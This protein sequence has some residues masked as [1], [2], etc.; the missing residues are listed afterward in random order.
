MKN[1]PSS[2][3]R[4]K[5]TITYYDDNAGSFF[6]A[7]IQIDASSLYSLFLRYLTPGAHILDAGCGSGRDSLYFIQHGYKVTALDASE[8][9][10]Q[11]ASQLIGQP[12]LN[13]KFDEMNFT[14]VFDGIWACASLLHIPSDGLDA[15]IGQLAQALRPGGILYMSFKYGRHEEMRNGRFFNDMDE[16]KLRTWL[17]RQSDLNLLDVWKTRDVR[18]DRQSEQWLNVIVKRSV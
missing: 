18:P 1:Q 17:N 12:V 10:A 14:S 2:D 9:L 6:D 8:Q 3:S 7:T 11:K 15:V 13:L 5:Q 4:I 16:S